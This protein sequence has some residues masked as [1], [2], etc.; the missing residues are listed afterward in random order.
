MRWSDDALRSPFACLRLFIENQMEELPRTGE[1]LENGERDDFLAYYDRFVPQPLSGAALDAEA[2]GGARSTYGHA[3]ERILGG[4]PGRPFRVL[5]AGCGFGTESLLFAF[6]GAEVT[7]ND[8][9]GERV[10]AAEKRPAFWEKQTGRRLALR[11]RLAN[12][13]DQPERD[14]FDLIWVHNAITHIHP[15]DGFLRLCRDLLAPGGEVVIVDVNK[16]SLRRRI[17]AGREEHQGESKYTTR[18]DPSTGKEVVY[19]VER[20]LGLLEQCRLL[21]HA[22]LRVSYR[23]CYLGGHARAGDIAWKAILRPLD[24]SLAAV[25]LGSR[26][27]VAGRKG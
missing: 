1:F 2:R 25:F 24:R 8:L 3:L 13:F 9:R 15:V 4:R 6:A 14:H 17:R 22:G 18:V 10:R 19:A 20:D 7:G 23:E 11:F 27:V 5:D 26:Y 12:I 21:E 16:T